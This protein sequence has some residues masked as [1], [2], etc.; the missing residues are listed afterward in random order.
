VGAT[1]SAR[2][3]HRRKGLATWRLVRYA[4]DCAPRTLKEVPV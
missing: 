1:S 3:G 2:Q 4:D